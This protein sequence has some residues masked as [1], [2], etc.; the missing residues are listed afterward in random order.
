MTL[1]KYSIL[2]CNSQVKWGY[3]KLIPKPQ[4]LTMS[5]NPHA[6]L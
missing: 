4:V 3:K 5:F 6:K 1:Q 2:D